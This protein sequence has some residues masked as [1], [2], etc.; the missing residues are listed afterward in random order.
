MTD[1]SNRTVLITGAA[2]RIGAIVCR[3]LHESGAN[4]IIHYRSS[5]LEADLLADALN[6]IRPDSAFTVQAD[7]CK[8]SELSGMI[9]ECLKFTGQIDVLINNASSFYPTTVGEITEEDWEDLLCSN[10]KAPLFLSQAATAELK[11][12][13]GCIINMVDI[14]GMRPLK[15]YPVY[16]AAKAGLIMLTKSLAKELGPDIRVNGVAPGAILWPEDEINQV[17]QDELIAKTALKREG[18][19]ENIA[20]AIRYLILDAEYTTGH[21]IP[22]DGGRTL[23]Q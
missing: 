5:R 4:V 1:L 11:K 21:I 6:A 12:Q 13:K 23:N 8:T 16:S 17:S 22:V 15:K 10:L 14:H 9:E 3:V 18:N 20:T 2:K 7:L 19:P